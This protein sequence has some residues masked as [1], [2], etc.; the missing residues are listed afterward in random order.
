VVY[1]ST[2]TVACPSNTGQIIAGGQT[3]VGALPTCSTCTCGDATGVTCSAPVASLFAMQGCAGAAACASVALTTTCQEL[4]SSSS[5]ACGQGGLYLSVS[6]PVASGGMC[7]ASPQT[8]TVPMAQWSTNFIACG[9][10]TSPVSCS[11]N[12]VCVAQA[13]MGG[14]VCVY[15]SG[16][17]ACPSTSLYTNNRQVI[18][19]KFDDTRACSACSC[20]TAQAKCSGAGAA[21]SSDPSCGSPVS[22]AVPDTCSAVNIATSSQYNVQLTQVPTG[23]GTCAASGGVAGG[24][25]APANMVT[26]CCL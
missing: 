26:I 3:P 8:Y 4:K 16:D 24:M 13:N 14:Q 23:D 2:G 22:I 6:A 10:T 25:V 19:T 11:T 12:E 7:T 17:V 5:T 1:Q 20:G 18:G 9:T 15:Q 21:L